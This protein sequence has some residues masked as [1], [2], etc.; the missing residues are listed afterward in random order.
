VIVRIWHGWTPPE[1]ASAYEDFVLEEVFQSMSEIDGF[2]GAELGRRDEGEEVAF[3]TI[4]RFDSL[5]AVQ[6]FAG[7]DY[8]KAVVPPRGRELLSRFDEHSAHYNLVEA[9]P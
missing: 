4:T 9:G 1:N 5:E 7:D 6:R 8:A 2:I 3:L